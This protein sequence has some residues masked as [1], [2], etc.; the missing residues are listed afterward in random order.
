MSPAAVMP[1]RLRI[2][3]KAWPSRKLA[4][5]KPVLASSVQVLGWPA[6]FEVWLLLNWNCPTMLSAFRISR[7]RSVRLPPVFSVWRPLIQVTLSKIWKSFWFVIRGWL[8]LAPRSRMFWKSICVIADVA[9]E[10]LMPGMPTACARF[11]PKSIEVMLNLID[12]QP[13]RASFSQ[14]LPKLW[15]S[16]NAKPWALMLPSPAPNVAPLSPC[17]SVAGCSR[18]VFS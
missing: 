1:E 6:Q 10:V 13:K 2:F 7:D 14:L 4:T 12:V 5:S 15:V 16:L 11:S 8:L 9:G 17:G 3:W 18:C